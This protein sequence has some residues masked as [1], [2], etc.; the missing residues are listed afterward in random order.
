MDCQ[1]CYMYCMPFIEQPGWCLISQDRFWRDSPRSRGFPG[2]RFC[3]QKV[4][5]MLKGSIH[6]LRLCGPWQKGSVCTSPQIDGK[7]PSFKEGGRNKASK[8]C[9][10]SSPKKEEQWRYPRPWARWRRTTLALAGFS[11][12]C[13]GWTSQDLKLDMAWRAKMPLQCSNK[14][15]QSLF[16]IIT[17]AQNSIQVGGNGSEWEVLRDLMP[18]SAT[19]LVVP[20]AEE[21]PVALFGNQVCRSWSEIHIFNFLWSFFLCHRFNMYDS[22][23]SNV[24]ELKSSAGGIL[25][26]IQID[27]QWTIM[28]NSILMMIF[29]YCD[30]APL[31]RP[32]FAYTTESFQQWFTHWWRRRF[33]RA[34]LLP[35]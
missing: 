26:D 4:G 17:I 3:Q 15:F 19:K 6:F 35:G 21:A 34:F 10:Y 30:Y 28:R 12:S 25:I 9:P 23:T 22:Y 29:Y 11:F 1:S 2:V 18:S 32:V 24:A 8:K 13:T 31:V 27:T 33:L 7:G 16:T 14:S 20:T 5:N